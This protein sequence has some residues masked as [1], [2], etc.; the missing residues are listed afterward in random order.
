MTT[1]LTDDTLRVEH[2]HGVSG[3]GAGAR[4][5]AAERVRVRSL[6][7]E[8]GA[9]LLRG[10]GIRSA[11]EVAQYA[12]ALGITPMAERERFATRREYPDGGQSASEWPPDEQLCLHH[13]LSYAAEV[14]SVLLFGCL[15]APA[16]GGATVVADGAEVLRLLPPELAARFRAKGW[17]LTRNYRE[18]GVSLYESFGTEDPQAI[19]AYCRAEAIG[20]EW[21]P[22]AVLRTRQR[23]AA[24][25]THP[26]TGEEVWF[27]QAAFL[28]ELTL[29]P[30]IRAYLTEVYGP[31]AMPFTTAYGDG[32]PIPPQDVAAVNEAYRLAT[33]REPWQ[34]GDLLL[35]DNL[36]T[37]HG[38]E[39]YEGE[40]EVAVVLGDPVRLPDHVLN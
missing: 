40:R 37:A 17:Q 13:E 24:V 12:L 30:M 14:P 9:V 10:L 4:W 1:L 36:R 16:A 35:V 2:A 3:P 20:F 38:R 19:G 22:D 31:D 26:A 18:V 8:H 39:P 7:A 32:T 5:A 15:T 6:L 11:A 25:L 28:N 33:R 34:Q 29:D 21:L 27:N 23:R